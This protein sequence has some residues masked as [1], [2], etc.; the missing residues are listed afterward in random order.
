MKRPFHLLRPQSLRM[1]DPL[2]PPP[3]PWR[4]RIALAFFVT[5][6]ALIAAG[7][8]RVDGAGVWFRAGSWCGVVAYFLILHH[9]DVRRLPV[10]SRGGVATYVRGAFRVAMAYALL[11]IFGLAATGVLLALTLMGD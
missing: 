1:T 11:A 10:Q 7:F 8:A 9:N 6:V 3:A 2:E 4:P 5:G